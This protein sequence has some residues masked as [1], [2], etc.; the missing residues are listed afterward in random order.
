MIPVSRLN[1]YPSEPAGRRRPVHMISLRSSYSDKKTHMAACEDRRSRS[2]GELARRG[3]QLKGGGVGLSSCSTSFCDEDRS[4]R[5]AGLVATSE[6]EASKVAFLNS[7]LLPHPSVLH[8]TMMT[9]HADATTSFHRFTLR[10]AS[11]LLG[12]ADWRC[13]SVVWK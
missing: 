10:A 4:S 2:E 9:A 11:S 5:A 8:S 13:E 3:E 1:R 7:A 12:L 6:K